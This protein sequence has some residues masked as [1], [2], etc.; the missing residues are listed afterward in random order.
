M[1]IL[2][3][4]LLALSNNA[5]ADSKASAFTT[6]SSPAITD[7]LLAIKDPSGT[8]LNRLVSISTVFKSANV[9]V[10]GT[11]VGV[12][13][14]NP[15]QI[16]DVTGTV[17]A[18]A[19][20]G[21]GSG[22]SGVTTSPAGSGTE[23]QY[24]NGSSFG[25]VTSSSISGANVGFGTTAPTSALTIY[26]GGNN[27]GIPAFNIA[28]STGLPIFTVKNATTTSGGYGGIGIGTTTVG[29]QLG[30]DIVSNVRV[31]GTDNPALT[32]GTD[33]KAFIVPSAQTNGSLE[34]W[35]NGPSGFTAQN[36]IFKNNG[37]VQLLYNL[38]VGSSAPQARLVV[39][40]NGATASTNSFQ[41]RDS[42]FANKFLINDAGNVGI[43]TATPGSKLD[44]QGAIRA[45]TATSPITKKSGANTACNTT[46]AG[47]M[48][49]WAQNTSDFSLVDCADT[50]ADA[51]GCLGP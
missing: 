34:V 9:T 36:T 46:C 22:L 17:R 6:D 15:G 10:T 41:V 3:F 42:A 49:I 5:F 29:S 26:D 1:Y 33:F 12:G 43:N 8:P 18:T 39:I 11:N 40:G 7:K 35:T 14:T 20:S 24:K 4:I 45:F 32:F 44:I 23:L 19:F 31:R 2:L 13:S 25:A 38:G 27:T 28:T 51:C 48:C 16:L 30:A 37:N 47:T 50:T 21:D